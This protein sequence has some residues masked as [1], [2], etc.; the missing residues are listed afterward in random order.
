MKRSYFT[1]LA[2]FTKLSHLRKVCSLTNASG[3]ANRWR[4]LILAAGVLFQFLVLIGMYVTAQIPLWTGREIRIET[5]PVDPR[6]LFRGNYARL[7]YAFSEL[8]ADEFGK[9]APLRTGE[10]VY[11]RLQADQQGLYR[12]AGASLEP[13]ADGVF[14]RGRVSGLRWRAEGSAYPVRYGIEAF[15]APREKALKLESALRQGGVAVL[16]V[17]SSGRTRLE[18]VVPAA[19]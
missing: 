16:R 19:D 11:I 9:E 2:Y 7:Q 8:D 18:R 6:S 17:S 1:R 4:L 3:L 10:V 12:Y 13:P 15:F 14:L 5:V